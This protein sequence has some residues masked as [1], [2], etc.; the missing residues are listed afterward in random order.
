[1]TK[2]FFKLFSQIHE[3]SDCLQSAKLKPSVKMKTEVPIWLQR[4]E[5]YE[6][7]N[8]MRGFFDQTLFV[9]DSFTAE[10]I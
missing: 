7:I 5:I 3:A 1:M 6:E 9:E 10:G 2:R 4:V 8:I